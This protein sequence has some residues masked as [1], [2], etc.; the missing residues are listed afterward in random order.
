MDKNRLEIEIESPELVR[1][2]SRRSI[3]DNVD[4][5]NLHGIQWIRQL[6]HRRQCDQRQSSYAPVNT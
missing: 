4:P 5:E 3:H 2:L 1:P 6:H